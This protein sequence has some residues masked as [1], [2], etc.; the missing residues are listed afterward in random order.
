MKART[1]TDWGFAGVGFLALA[2]LF[3]ATTTCDFQAK[4]I[5]QSLSDGMDHPLTAE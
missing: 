3:S 1:L 2:L 5:A 4:P